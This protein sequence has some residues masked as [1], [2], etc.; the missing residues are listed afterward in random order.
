MSWADTAL[1]SD[2]ELAHPEAAGSSPPGRLT[3]VP[4]APRAPGTPR[5]PRTRRTTSSGAGLV[6]ISEELIPWE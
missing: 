2:H 5:T 4:R 3:S 1:P 6:I